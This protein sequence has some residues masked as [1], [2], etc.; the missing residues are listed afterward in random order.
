MVKRPILFNH[1]TASFP[2]KQIWK[3][4]AP[5][6]ITFFA[7]EASRNAI[8]TFDTLRKRGQVLV[9][10]CYM[11][12]GHVEMCNHLLLFCLAVL[13]IW[14]MV[15]WLLGVSWV[16]AGSIREEIWAWKGIGRN[17]RFFSLIPLTIFWIIW[18][19]I[20]RRGFEGVEGDMSELRDRWFHLFGSLILG[21]DLCRVEDFEYLIDCLTNMWFFMYMGCTPLVLC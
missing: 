4:Q 21:H 20:N 3:I 16:M 15:Y 1:Y 12:K 7:W 14:S 17:G 10:G 11:C 8:L 9:N 2:A 18:K 5:P 6:K 19:E 13:H